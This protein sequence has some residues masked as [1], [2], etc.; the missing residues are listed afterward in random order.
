MGLATRT[1]AATRASAGSSRCRSDWGYGGRDGNE[2]HADNQLHECFEE[3]AT[4]RDVKAPPIGQGQTHDNGCDEPGVVADH[5]A[6]GRYRDHRGELSGGA[7]HFAEPEP[8]EQQPQQ[9]GAGHA[10]GQADA[11]AGRELHKLAAR[12]LARA[13]D[14]GMEHQRAEDSADRVDQ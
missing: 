8:A 5:V 9:R 13:R 2:E 6:C 12:S 1:R 11:D 14:N 3:R 10:A 7:E 4:R